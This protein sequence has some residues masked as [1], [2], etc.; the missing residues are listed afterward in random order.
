MQ[1]ADLLAEFAFMSFLEY[2]WHPQ[3]VTKFAFVQGSINTGKSMGKHEKD[4]KGTK[5]VQ[6]GNSWKLG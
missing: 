2:R 6:K 4:E 5:L 3:T 1:N